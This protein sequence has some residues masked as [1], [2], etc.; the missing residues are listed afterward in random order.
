MSKSNPAPWR[1]V[2]LPND[3]GWDVEL[4]RDGVTVDLLAYRVGKGMAEQIARAAQRTLRVVQQPR[5][6][7]DRR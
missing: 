5:Q 6:K 3:R 2:L 7:E 4:Q 1:V